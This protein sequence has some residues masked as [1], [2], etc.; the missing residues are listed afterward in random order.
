VSEEMKMT[1]LTDV[2]DMA[3]TVYRNGAEQERLRWTRAVQAKICLDHR[4]TATCSHQTCYTLD[5]L[6]AEMNKEQT[7]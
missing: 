3:Q 4:E 2:N 6:L 1:W 7:K 5:W